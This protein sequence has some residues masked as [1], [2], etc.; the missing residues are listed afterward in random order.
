MNQT[1]AEIFEWVKQQ[2]NN[3]KWA[4]FKIAE[5]EKFTN[6]LIS[7]PDSVIPSKARMKELWEETKDLREGAIGSKSVEDEGLPCNCGRVMERLEGSSE[8]EGIRKD[9]FCAQCLKYFAV[10][11][12]G[13]VEILPPVSEPVED[14]NFLLEGE[15]EYISNFLKRC[16]P[17]NSDPHEWSEGEHRYFLTTHALRFLPEPTRFVNESD[18][19]I[20]ERKIGQYTYY[21]LNRKTTDLD[22]HIGE[23]LHWLNKQPYDPHEV[24]QEDK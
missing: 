12:S 22:W 5:F 14:E 17:Y 3:G 9:A 16:E 6:S 8:P 19:E 2:S 24:A 15:A 21:L 11:K 18:K 7:E 13:L 10:H 20:A 4:M 23:F 1:T